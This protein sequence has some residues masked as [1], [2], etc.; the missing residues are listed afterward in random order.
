[1]QEADDSEHTAL[2]E[3]ALFRIAK[4]LR[5]PKGKVLLKQWDNQ[6]ELDKN[7]FADG[8]ASIGVYGTKKEFHGVFTGWDLDGGGSLS[9]KEIRIALAADPNLSQAAIQADAATTAEAKN[10]PLFAVS[11]ALT[12]GAGAG[13]MSIVSQIVSG[14]H[15]ACIQPHDVRAIVMH[16]TP[17]GQ[18]ALHR[19]AMSGQPHNIIQSLLQMGFDAYTL[20]DQKRSPLMMAAINNKK[21]AVQALITA[22]DESAHPSGVRREKNLIDGLRFAVMGGS[23]DVVNILVDAIGDDPPKGQTNEKLPSWAAVKDSSGRDVLANAKDAGQDDV[24]AY[25]ETRLKAVR[26]KAAAA[27]KD[28]WGRAQAAALEEQK[29]RRRSVGQLK[30]PPPTISSSAMKRVVALFDLE[31]GAQSDAAKRCG[32]GVVWNIDTE[33][34]TKVRVAFAIFDSDGSGALDRRKLR[35]ILAMPAGGTAVR[36]GQIN[37]IFDEYDLDDDDQLQ[38][39][40]FSAFWFSLAGNVGPRKKDSSAS[41]FDEKRQEPPTQSKW[42]PV[43]LG[44]DWSDRNLTATRRNSS[45]AQ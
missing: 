10:H 4:V 18:T 11:M 9:V 16:R 15:P 41:S 21:V 30:G 8:L 24:I 17:G 3:T 34:N 39:S 12:E 40:E 42:G 31:K 13:D 22:G 32:G 2:N 36:D 1:M 29:R 27:A 23:L 6:G 20:D 7:M 35:S 14:T 45:V 37:A 19:A 25:L 44:L 33:I 5:T 28:K 43:P 26:D 38:F